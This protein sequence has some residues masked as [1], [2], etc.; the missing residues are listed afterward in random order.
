VSSFF[1]KEK[2]KEKKGK[3]KGKKRKQEKGKRKK[4]DKRRAFFLSLH[5]ITL[6]LFPQQLKVAA[7]S[8][9]VTVL[10][11]KT[12]FFHQQKP[13][14]LSIRQSAYTLP[15]SLNASLQPSCLAAEFLVSRISCMTR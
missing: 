2:E 1:R 12:S 6:H 7:Y 13:N 4:G 11:Q 8:Q 3:G 15:T 9:S 14:P 5:Y 10:E